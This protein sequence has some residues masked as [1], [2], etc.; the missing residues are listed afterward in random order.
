MRKIFSLTI[1]L[2]LLTSCSNAGVQNNAN[3]ENF[4]TENITQTNSVSQLGEVVFWAEQIEYNGPIT[5]NLFDLDS[6]KAVFQKEINLV[7][8]LGPSSK[9]SS[10]SNYAVQYN[11]TTEEIF[12][13]TR[14]E[15][16]GMG[17]ECVNKDGTCNDRIYKLEKNSDTPEVLY[18][19]EGTI[20]NWIVNPLDNSILL[21]QNT[22]DEGDTFKKIDTENGAVL[23]LVN[24]EYYGGRSLSEMKLSSSGK[25]TFQSGIS[26]KDG[27]DEAY[28]SKFDNTNGDREEFRVATG[29]GLYVMTNISPNEKYFVHYEDKRL[30]LSEFGK[31]LQMIEYEGSIENYNIF[32]SGDSKKFMIFTSEG[33]LY[34][35]LNT[36]ELI[37]V[38]ENLYRGVV[39][40]PSVDNIVLVSDVIDVYNAI[41]GTFTTISEV[42]NSGLDRIK[43][44]QIF[45]NL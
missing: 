22:K 15:S 40:E 45:N 10:G 20:S 17:D 11:P 36:K 2:L 25:Y 27:L 3:E 18:D 13:F 34:Y 9:G 24:N 14:G 43:G 44:A 39:W 8:S 35:D 31:S 1:A 6:K 30:Y 7:D 37:K 4:S 23:F 19:L 32:W 28:T 29:N 42:N 5:I 16:M 26:Y 38:T 21:T 12:L 41:D 33:V